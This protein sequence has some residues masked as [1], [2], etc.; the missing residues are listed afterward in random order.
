M[1]KIFIFL[2][3]FILSANAFAQGKRVA[4][5]VGNASYAKSPLVN[6]LNDA[7][8]VGS[9][10]KGL[11]F[12]IVKAKDCRTK[13]ELRKKLE[14]FCSLASNADAGLFF[15][16][17]HGMQLTKTGENYLIPTEAEMTSEADVEEECIGLNY[18]LNKMDESGINM[19]I[20]IIDACRD[21]P[22]R[23][24]YRGGSKGLSTSVE[25]PS[26]TFIAFATSANNVA[27][28]GN[29][30]R[31]SPFTAALLS[32]LNSNNL[33]INNVFTEVKKIVR[34]RTNGEQRP[35]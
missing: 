25:A 6:P 31:N 32:A 24:W 11:G 21:N 17:G 7:D 10:L 28:D 12:T 22:F 5:I 34:Q 9:K 18:I 19:K 23:T 35:W 14:E 2:I 30:Y 16:S 20:A 27:A 13:R 4:L 26:G 15:Y 33:E 3:S 29:N 8:D 1:K